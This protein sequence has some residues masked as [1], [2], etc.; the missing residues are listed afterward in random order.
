MN[1]PRILVVEDDASMGRAIRRILGTFEVTL[2]RT[3]NAARPLVLNDDFQVVISDVHIGDDSG[4]DLFDEMT[5]LRAELTRRYL[6]I[7]AAA[8]DPGVMERLRRTGAPFLRKPF[9][10]DAFRELVV[11]VIVSQRSR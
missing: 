9:D 8:D 6:F 11:W 10:I 2:A 1:K 4:L 7:S 3:T 5:L